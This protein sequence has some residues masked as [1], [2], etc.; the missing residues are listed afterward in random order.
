[1]RRLVCVGV[2]SHPGVCHLAR[3]ARVT[4]HRWC[5]CL[6]TAHIWYVPPLVCVWFGGCFTRPRKLQAY[7]F[8]A[9]RDLLAGQAVLLR[10]QAVILTG[11]AVHLLRQVIILMWCDT[12]IQH[13]CVCLLSRG[14]LI[15]RQRLF[16]HDLMFP[17]SVVFLPASARR[18]PIPSINV[19]Q[20]SITF[21]GDQ[22]PT[23]PC[24]VRHVQ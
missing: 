22:L 14:S 16:I 21:Q 5:V 24:L 7:L 6:C 19:G 15:L 9:L 4:S 2:T 3:L 8:V 23:A 1:M 10:H 12:R 18:V 17:L 13:R 11:Q 20:C